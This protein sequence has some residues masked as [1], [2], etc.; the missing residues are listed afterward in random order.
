MV[1]LGLVHGF[2]GLQ[3]NVFFKGSES[4]RPIKS[5]QTNC[6]KRGFSFTVVLWETVGVIHRLFAGQWNLRSVKAILIH[7][8]P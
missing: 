5:F 2:S 6:L 4:K 3:Y 7:T 1:C 8:R